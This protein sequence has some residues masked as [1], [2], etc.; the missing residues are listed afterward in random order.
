VRALVACLPGYGHFHPLV[1][2][3]MA[4]QG[5]GHDVAFATERRFCDRAE[6]AGFRAFP[7]GIGPGQVFERTLARA[8]AA[9]PDDTARFGAQMFAAVAA[10][11][12]M[13]ELVAVVDGWRPDLVIHDVT[14]YAGPLAAA[15]AGIPAVAHSLGP[16][17]PPE[18][19]RIGAEL[20]EPLWRE[21]GVPSP[22]GPFGATY[23][24]MCPPSLQSPEIAALPT[25][26]LPLRP[27]P[28]DAVAGE[29]LPA[30]ADELGDRPAVYVT[31]G[32]VD[33]DAPGVIEA[34][35][36]GL[37]DEPMDLVVTVGP[38]RAP[39]E[40]GP[41]PPHVHVERYLPQSLLLPR[42]AA[43]VCHS[44]SGTTLAALGQGLPLLLLP[45][46]ANQFDIAGR[47]EVLGVGLRLLPA[48][49][50]PEAV[51]RSVRTLID[52]PDFTARA[53]DVAAEIRAMPA[54]ADLVP[55]ME[56]L[57][58]HDMPEH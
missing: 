7:A 28:F 32:T 20:V 27:V 17:F 24:D 48:D 55:A 1:P 3:A 44:G 5:A 40:L 58:G 49:V 56:A 34:V 57:A 15:R 47:C 39:D 53:G 11:A 46:G 37:R 36:A 2:L 13:A 23:L 35:V 18:L 16:L 51:R 31:L 45:Q 9:R 54:P 8:D 29:S 52:S 19:T 41:Q 4:L 43:V 50:S 21:W 25:T 26:V 10:P 38:N 42:C 33:N 22:A 14:D 30:W 6:A 12:K